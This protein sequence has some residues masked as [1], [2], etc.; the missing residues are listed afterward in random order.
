MMIFETQKRPDMGGQSRHKRSFV[1]V[2]NALPVKLKN[3][4]YNI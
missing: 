2:S 4:H 1:R 3:A